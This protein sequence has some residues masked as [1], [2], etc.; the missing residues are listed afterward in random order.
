MQKEVSMMSGVIFDVDGTLLDTMQMWKHAGE[1][2]LAMLG[3]EAEPRLGEILFPMSMT[4]GATYLKEKYHLSA[5][6]LDIIKGI[7][8]VIHD[9]YRY[10]AKLKPG[11]LE[12]LIM[13]R[14]KKIKMSVATSSDR[15]LIEASFRRLSLMEF[16]DG[17]YTCTEVGADKKEPTIYIKAQEVMNTK[18][19]ETWVFEDALYAVQTAHNAGFRVAGVYDEVSHKDQEK[20]REVVDFYFYDLCDA[21]EVFHVLL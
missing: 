5:N 3:I 13:L 21:G 8:E 6:V 7:H 14:E 4:G 12:F 15:E 16:F 20:L 11:V 17:I 19:S 9:F 18:I 10:E 1:R 2:Y